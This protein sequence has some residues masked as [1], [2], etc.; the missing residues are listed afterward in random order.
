MKLPKFV[1]IAPNISEPSMGAGFVLCTKE[2]YYLGRI[3]KL[4]P[5]PYSILNY[6]NEFKPLVYAVVDG[7]SIVITFAGNLSGYKVRVNSNEW[8]KDLQS[9]YEKMA[10]WF[11][12]EKILNNAGYYK[13]YINI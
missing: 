8:E 2:P 7:Y 11:Y 13:R 10:V 12:E 9:V 5:G 1:F 6:K 3:I 4:S